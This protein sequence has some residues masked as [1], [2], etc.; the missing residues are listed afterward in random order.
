MV[1]ESSL[2]RRYVWVTTE[3]IEYATD[4]CDGEHDEVSRLKQWL[5]LKKKSDG[6]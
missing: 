1:G 2:D 3:S 5:T 4:T 6:G